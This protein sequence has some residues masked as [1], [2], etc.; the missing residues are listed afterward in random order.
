MFVPGINGSII[1]NA[2]SGSRLKGAKKA[3]FKADEDFRQA[4]EPAKGLVL[5]AFLPLPAASFTRG[6]LGIDNRSG[7][8]SEDQKKAVAQN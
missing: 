6:A 4:N 5:D 3:Q 8:F 2:P 7:N 1:S